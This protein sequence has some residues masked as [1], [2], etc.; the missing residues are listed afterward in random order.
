MEK[1]PL[2]LLMQSSGLR[3]SYIQSCMEL[4]KFQFWSRRQDPANRFKPHEIVKLAKIL[5]V[6]ETAV[7]EAVIKTSAS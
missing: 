5:D 3:I 1:S 2:E 7:L 4:T 6:D